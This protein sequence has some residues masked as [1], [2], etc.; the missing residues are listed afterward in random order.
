MH[1]D[2]YHDTVC[3]WCRIGKAHL[4]AAL[5]RWDGPP[6]TLAYHTFF[7]N[8][9]VPDAGFPFREYML[10][11]GQG[12]ITLEQWFERP[13]ELGAEAGL[14]FNFDLIERAPNTALSH[15]LIQLAPTEKREAIIDSLY[16]A[17]FEQGRDIGQ[18]E[19][20]A[21]VAGEQGLNPRNIRAQLER[22]AKRREVMADLLL[23]Q[24]LG[25]RG[26]PFFVL[27][28]RLAFSGAQPPDLILEAMR[29]ALQFEPGTRFPSV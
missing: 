4:K 8:A 21:A 25:V 2:L 28:Q 1:I 24:R 15:M 6:V 7:L 9:D 16:S 12:R 11:K 14:V 18:I 17:Y 13:R 5:A 19:V 3:P 29:E 27:N 20:L 23:A 10:E 26:V 22:G